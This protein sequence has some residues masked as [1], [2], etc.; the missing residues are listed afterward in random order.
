MNLQELDELVSNPH[1]DFGHKRAILEMYGR[2][3]HI[4]YETGRSFD[5]AKVNPM[6]FY[7]IGVKTFPRE[8][9]KGT[10]EEY[11]KACVSNAIYL[12]ERFPIVFEFYD[13]LINGNVIKEASTDKQ[14]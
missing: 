11:I 2:K 9:F 14:M 10:S 4:P 8:K 13:E 7:N 5:L 1:V 12:Y 6:R 3:Q